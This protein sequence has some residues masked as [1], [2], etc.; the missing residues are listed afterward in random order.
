M[1]NNFLP[2]KRPFQYL[3]STT[4][5]Q[6][7]NYNNPY[8][9]HGGGVAGG[10]GGGGGGESKRRS[11]IPPPP[12]VIPPGHG[13]FRMLC[14]VSKIGQV[15][16]KSGSIVK[17]F[18]KETGAKIRV[19]EPVNDSDER[20]I[21]IIAPENPKKMIQLKGL[22]EHEVEQVEVS[23]AQETLVRVFDRVLD[24]DSEI[25]GLFPPGGGNVCCRLLADTSQIGSVI[26]K[27]GQIVAKI[28]K[29]SGAKVRVLPAE[30]LPPCASPSDELI[31]IMGDI[32]PVKKALVSI[33]RRLQ[34]RP[35]LEKAQAAGSLPSV[36]SSSQ[37]FPDPQ[38]EFP[39]RNH[40]VPPT[41]GSSSQ[42]FS[43]PRVEFLHRNHMP[44]IAGNSVDYA[45]R[46]HPLATEALRNSMLEPA[47]T[48][49]EVVYRLLCSNE[50]V[51]GVI[52]KGGTIVRT[53]QNETGA[54]ISFGSPVPE[55]DER[56]ITITASESQHTQAQNA[57]VRVFVRSVEVGVEKG[58]ESGPKK[59]APVSA[60]LLIPTSQVG[61]LIG[62]GGTIITE[63]RMTTGAY[64]R[65]LGGDQVPK[66]ASENDEVVQITG[67]F[68]NVQNALLHI[69]GRL[70]QNLFP[71]R[72]TNGAESRTYLSTVP[73]VG[74]F[75]RNRELESSTL[76]PSVGH[77]HHSERQ[78]TLT[79][80][81][82]HLGI[83]HPSD[84]SRRW[85]SQTVGG[86][87]RNTMDVGKGMTS[88]GDNMELARKSAIVTN[89]T[90]EIQVPEHV[91]GSVYGE[92]GSNLKRLRQ[93]SGAQVEVR[94]PRPGTDT[95][96][97]IISGTPDQTQAAQSL[98]QAF[99]LSGRP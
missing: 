43:D 54:S 40:M 60:R 59:G 76:Y 74:H 94:D 26:G 37:T 80:S 87:L 53:L 39:R 78:A 83:S 3:S 48:P 44:P 12:L 7:N 65:I 52:G 77:P 62:K 42:T 56:V 75:G 73:E 30:E 95:G 55:S 57:V 81:M 66:C 91:F 28:R 71:G 63:I 41:S 5:M 69:T 79:Q 16:G 38:K 98:L 45:S 58:L 8:N 17:L 67:E 86:S 96:M 47:K 18:R 49:Q 51:G 68:G 6:E 84:D 70:W 20:L 14:H 29:D 1:E 23:P 10:G 72:V 2:L 85:P 97:V 33:S 9:N 21:I 64:I 46:G 34:D 35:P 99:I 82:D 19:E 36:S 50:K 4:T 31:Q 92:N 89:T 88:H 22:N 27:G 13:S 90:L 61:C 24:V 93:I 25:E 15:I 11:K 32:L